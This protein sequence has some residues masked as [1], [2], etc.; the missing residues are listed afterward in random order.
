MLL[1]GKG[2]SAVSSQ[3][4]VIRIYV[5]GFPDNGEFRGEPRAI[6]QKW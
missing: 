4:S 1:F 5:R 6:A 2:E 3:L